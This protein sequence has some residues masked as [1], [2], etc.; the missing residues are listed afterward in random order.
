MAHVDEEVYLQLFM[1][2][3]VDH[4]KLPEYIPK[5]QGGFMLGYGT[6]IKVKTTRIWELY[7]QWK[8]VRVLIYKVDT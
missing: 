8:Y 7:I 5:E 3:I 1:Y 2:E 4:W 6:I